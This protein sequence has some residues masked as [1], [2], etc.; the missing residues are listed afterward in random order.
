MNAN[1]VCTVVRGRMRLFLAKADSVDEATSVVL[2]NIQAAFEGDGFVEKVGSGLMAIQ[3]IPETGNDN[4]S[5]VE[6]GG[7]DDVEQD[8]GGTGNTLTSLM[9]VAGGS[10]V[11]VIAVGSVYLWRRKRGDEHLEGM[12][13]QFAGDVTSNPSN[14]SGNTRYTPRPTSPL[15]QMI[16]GS[17]R[18]G[19]NTSILSSANNMSPVYELE[20]ADSVV[21]SESG[22][23][24]EAGRTDEDDSTTGASTAYGSSMLAS[25]YSTS[26]TPE[27]LGALPRPGMTVGDLDMEAPSDS[28]L[29]TSGETLSPVK[30]FVVPEDNLLD[31]RH[32]VEA[33]P[34]SAVDDEALLFEHQ[35]QVENNS[36]EEED[37][38]EED[39]HHHHPH[40]HHEDRHDETSPGQTSD[41]YTI[42]GSPDSC[43]LPSP[44]MEDIDLEEQP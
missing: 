10:A 1:Y 25:K 6:G 28:E 26:G 24:N 20:D 33:S 35:D 23:T 30:M 39:R 38:E 19:D 29:D 14:E 40:D 32:D 7:S 44:S 41:I 21:V 5:K 27:Y 2:Q 43:S 36:Q 18:L 42:D 22:Y 12:A 37:E 4:N 11:L 3:F 16:P 9:F 15:S 31:T 34:A 13:T 17:Y 8:V